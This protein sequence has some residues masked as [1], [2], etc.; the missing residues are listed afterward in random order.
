VGGAVKK[1]LSAVTLFLMSCWAFAAT[2]EMEGA[3]APAD[4]VDVIYVVIFVVIFIT[5]IIGFFVYLFLN[6]KKQ[7][8]DQ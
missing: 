7:K 5:S 4:T 6:E 2:R 1:L 8:P 3:T